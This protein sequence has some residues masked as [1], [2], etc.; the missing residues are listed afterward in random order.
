LPLF[1]SGTLGQRVEKTIADFGLEHTIIRKGFIL[2]V[3]RLLAACDLLVFPAITN[4]FARPIVEA[5]AMGK[6]TV[7]SHF[8]IIEELVKHDETGLLVPPGDPE[9]LAEA[10]LEL[11]KDPERSARLGKTAYAL[12]R[13]RYDATSRIQ[14]IVEIYDQLLQP[15]GPLAE[16]LVQDDKPS[17]RFLLGERAL[18]EEETRK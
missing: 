14:A 2:K 8:P 9:A 17:Q 18:G 11:L 5:A 15:P 10:I 1:G 12:A 16:R 6:P 3:E 13:S 7:A 4:H